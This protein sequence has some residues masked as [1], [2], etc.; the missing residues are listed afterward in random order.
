MQWNFFLKSM[1]ASEYFSNISWGRSNYYYLY[2]LEQWVV[3]FMSLEKHT[4]MMM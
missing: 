2:I 4:R 1:P 3:P